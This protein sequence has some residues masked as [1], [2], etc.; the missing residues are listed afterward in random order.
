[1][2][3]ASRPASSCRFSIVLAMSSTPAGAN[4]SNSAPLRVLVV[5]DLVDAA[6]IMARLLRH[7]DCDVQTAHAGDAALQ[8]AAE[9]APEIVLLDLG[10]PHIDGFEAARRLRAHPATARSQII[11]PSGY[12]DAAARDEAAVAGCFVV[13][14]PNQTFGGPTP[15]G[16]RSR[17]VDIQS[18]V[19]SLTGI[20]TVDL[21]RGGFE[22]R[23]ADG[24]PGAALT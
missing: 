16:S 3:I 15:T 14:V 19:G 7:L 2:T 13:A 22:A 21:I 9:F 12:G 17:V 23:W 24:P 4:E 18:V 10:L 20:C 1:M 11:A 8:I 5:D 6:Q